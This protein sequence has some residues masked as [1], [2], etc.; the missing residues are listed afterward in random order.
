M[1]MGHLRH[2]YKRGCILKVSFFATS[3]GVHLIYLFACPLS[4]APV[5]SRH[6]L[7]T[8]ELGLDL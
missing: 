3:L 4:E 1:N 2:K 7:A 5:G 8:A 6:Q